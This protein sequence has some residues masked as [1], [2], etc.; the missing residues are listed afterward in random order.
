MAGT[1]YSSDEH[2]QWCFA[3]YRSYNPDDNTY[4]ALSGEIRAS[5]SSHI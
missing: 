2:A 5:A 1:V 3:R 4:R